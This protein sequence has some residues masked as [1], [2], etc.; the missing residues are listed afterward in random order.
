M[1]RQQFAFEGAA[2][3]AIEP[4]RQSQRAHPEPH[5]RPVREHP[6]LRN[7]LVEQTRDGLDLI[8]ICARHA[9]AALPVM[10]IADL[11]DCPV[12]LAEADAAEGRDRYRRLVAG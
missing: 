3:A 6:F 5:A 8:R 4:H 12:C 2:A 7:V 9:F 1:A 10:R 11:A